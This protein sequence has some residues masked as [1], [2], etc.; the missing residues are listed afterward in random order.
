MKLYADLPS[1]RTWQLAGD[2][3]LL[4]WVVVCIWIAHG[5]HDAVLGLATP[6]HKL[7]E[8]GTSL[9]DKL[10]DAGSSVGDIPYVGDDVAKPFSGAGS[11][12]DQVAEAGRSQVAAVETL[13]TWLGVA[14]ALVPILIALAVYLPPRIRFVLRATAGQRFLDSTADLDLFALRALANQPLQVLARI[15]PDPAGAWRLRDPEVTR[16]LAALELRDVGLVPPDLG[17][18]AGSS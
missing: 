11:S 5:V 3:C 1:R 4:L 8:A 12:A 10:R 7:D 9:G 2:A 16:R 17:R 15:S 18:P 6:G 14:V 13:A